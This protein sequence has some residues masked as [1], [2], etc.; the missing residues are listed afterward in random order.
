MCYKILALSCCV[1]IDKDYVV[2]EGTD[3]EAIKQGSV[4]ITPQRRDLTN[5]ASP[6]ELGGLNLSLPESAEAP[7]D[8][9]RKN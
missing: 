3:F 2:A 9:P 1:L 5:Y 8:S 6:D 4:R 7:T